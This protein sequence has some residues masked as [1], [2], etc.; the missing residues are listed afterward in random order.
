[1]LQQQGADALRWY[2]FTA[3]PAGSARRFSSNLVQDTVR[4]FLL[5][6]WNTFSFFTTY[7]NL[8][9]FDPKR[10]AQFWKGEMGG[11]SLASA[12]PNELDRWIISELNDLTRTVTNEL[13]GYNPT[14]AGRRI[15]EFVDLLSNWYVRRS[16]RRFWKSE[17][18]EDKLWAYVTLYSCLVT[19][20]R[21]MAPLAPFVADEM[22]RVLVADTSGD[23]AHSVH[24]ADFPQADPELIDES[25]DKAVR[26]AMRVA[27]LG[28][29]ARSKAKVKVRQPL[30]KLLVEASAEEQPLL[31]QVEPQILDELNV[32]GLEVVSAGTLASYQVR[33]NLPLLGPKY[34]PRLG[35]LRSALQAVSASAV[36]EQAR[37]GRPIVAG[38]F[39]LA[40]EE[41]LVS[42][43]EQPGLAV[44]TEGL[45]GLTLAV[46][47]TLTPELEEEGL[48][49]E[50]VHRVQNLRKE[51]GLEIDDR[52]VVYVAGA[53]ERLRAVL[54][55]HGDYVRQETL[56]LELRFEPPATGAYS[57]EQVV[58]GVRL[59]LGVRRA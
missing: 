10:H 48:A 25:L 47:T 56:S 24:L 21:L 39:T 2:L 4:Q 16:R 15:Q 37:A 5:T 53:D 22:H 14:D 31:R 46:E 11:P 26:L 41:V 38:E 7:A 17:N 13:D 49:R 40:P 32:K 30:S 27:S 50:L 34:G 51:A 20:A 23:G 59:T 9:G 1:V 6:L 45:N 19:T 8:D 42:M 12:P 55:R 29:A 57:E 58:E 33:P 28:R 44:A 52:I 3:A 54:E 18:D 43:V 35:A 36:A